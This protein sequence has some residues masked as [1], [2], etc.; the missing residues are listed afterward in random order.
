MNQDG[1]PPEMDF[2]AYVML[3]NKKFIS[4]LRFYSSNAINV[5][6]VKQYPQITGPIIRRALFN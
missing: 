6:T 5:I 1:N 3:R 4:I 2:G